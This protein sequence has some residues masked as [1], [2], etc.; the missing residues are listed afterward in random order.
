MWDK[1]EQVHKPV[2]VVTEL[3]LQKKLYSLR[4]VDGTSMESF[5]RE[6]FDLR[7]QYIE[8][9]GEMSKRS[10]AFLV[11]NALPDSWDPLVQSIGSRKKDEIT[12]D[13]VQSILLE[14]ELRQKERSNSL[15]SDS[16]LEVSSTGKQP[17]KRR[18]LKGVKKKIDKSK[19]TCKACGQKGHWKGDPECLT[20]NGGH[21]GASANIAVVLAAHEIHTPKA[22]HDCIMKSQGS[23]EM[24]ITI[25]D[26]RGKSIPV[27]IKDVHYVQS[28]RDMLLSATTLCKKGCRFNFDAGGIDW[29]LPSG[30]LLARG[31][32][33]GKAYLM[34]CK[35]EEVAMIANIS[36]PA[37]TLLKW[38]RALAHA[39]IHTICD[40]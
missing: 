35:I 24:H 25:L 14:E 17:Y 20:P 26:P 18:N 38:H 28:A 4:Y 36:I 30:N 1:L 10:M 13:V 22:K 21:G 19:S 31:L 34:P 7:D 33:S 32:L 40:A 11:L 16:A 3:F 2:G 6:I 15:T 8:A 5:L 39:S 9:G 29:I 23:D 12:E 27:I 37:R